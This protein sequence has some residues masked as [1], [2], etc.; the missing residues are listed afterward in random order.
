MENSKSSFSQLKVP[1]RRGHS[2]TYGGR[3]LPDTLMPAL[4]ELGAAYRKAPSDRH[5]QKEFRH[6]LLEYAGKATPL[7][8][9]ARL[10]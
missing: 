5:F 9:G 6:H 7:H 10:T 8:L 3:Y 1:D 2:G 4:I